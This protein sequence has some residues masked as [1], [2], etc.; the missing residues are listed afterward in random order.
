MYLPRSTSTVLLDCYG[1]GLRGSCLSAKLSAFGS[2]DCSGCVEG[3]GPAWGEGGG[4][5]G[6]WGG[7]REGC[8]KGWSIGCH[9]RYVLLVKMNLLALRE[10]MF[11]LLVM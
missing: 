9:C 8:E 4:V 6:M 3:A 10:D 1:V 2:V 7:E 11:A 5:E